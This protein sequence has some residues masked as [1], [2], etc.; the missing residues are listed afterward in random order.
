M[1]LNW[2]SII[3][4][5]P[6]NSSTVVFDGYFTT[7]GTTVN[8]FYEGSYTPGWTDILLASGTSPFTSSNYTYPYD[9]VAGN[10]APSG[11]ILSSMSYYNP[12]YSGA[13]YNLDSTT[14]RNP[15]D[16]VHFSTGSPGSDQVEFNITAT[17][18]PS[19]F[20]EGTR[21][22]VLNQNLVDEYIRVELLKKGDLVKTYLHGYRRIEFMGSNQVFHDPENHS[23]GFPLRCVYYHK[24][25]TNVMLTGGHSI[26]VE[27]LGKY[28]EANDE[29]FE[30]HTPKIDD[31]YLLLCC[32]SDDFCLLEEPSLHNY[33]H[34]VLENNGNDEERFGVWTEGILTETPSKSY[35]L[36]HKE[37]FGFIEKIKG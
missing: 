19:C 8:H 21:I 29:M 7:S 5:S 37:R 18:D 15:K 20:I 14:S 30:G 9:G 16:T 32:L 24:K 34:F 1:S 10:F 26:L 25:D 35:F 4:Y 28:K 22:L 31:K 2:Y 13:I 33:Y 6:P 17:T 23:K 3:I 11:P 36:N 27:D 12:S